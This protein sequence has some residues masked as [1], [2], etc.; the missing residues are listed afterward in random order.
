MKR[1][2]FYF[3]I[4]A[5]SV[6]LVSCNRDDEP[7]TFRLDP[8][9][10]IYIKPSTTAAKA[11]QA[12]KSTAVHLTPLEVVKQADVLVFFNDLVSDTR[13]M[14]TFVGK[15]TISETP[16]LLRWGTDIIHDTDGYGNYGLQKDFIYGYDMVI[17]RGNF[18]KTDT[19]AYIPNSVVKNARDLILQAL[20]DKDTA[21]VY[22][23][24]E[25]AFRFIPITGPEYE[26][27]KNRGEN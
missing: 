24:F 19:I 17:C 26:I 21:A 11:F 6:M 22:G 3:L 5:I 14:A 7:K 15:D 20:Q 25:N 8:N 12:A 13:L 27:L 9:A 18:Q 1:K 4:L 23:H 10:K 16:A 2:R